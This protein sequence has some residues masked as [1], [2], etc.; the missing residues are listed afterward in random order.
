[1]YYLIDQLNKH[2]SQYFDKLKFREI[3]TESYDQ[4]VNQKKGEK[5]Y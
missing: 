1:M 5:N 3:Q 4:G 2:Y